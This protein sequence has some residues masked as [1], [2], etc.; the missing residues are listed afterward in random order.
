MLMPDGCD[1]ERGYLILRRGSPPLPVP[2]DP[3]LR[4]AFYAQ[5]LPVT[6]ESRMPLVKLTIREE[7]VEVDDDELAVL[8]G[9]NLIEKVL[10]DPVPPVPAKSQPAVKAAGSKES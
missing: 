4:A 7:P 1:A 5:A 8:R 9:Q 2:P 10:P 3:V 6:E